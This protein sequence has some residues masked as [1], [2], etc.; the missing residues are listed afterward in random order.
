M[1]DAN[2]FMQAYRDLQHK[3]PKQTEWTEGLKCLADKA[4]AASDEAW[5][6]FFIGRIA[7][8]EERHLEAVGCFQKALD[9][10][11]DHAFSLF[12]RGASLG[13]LERSDEAIAVYDDI[14]TR[15]G[16]SKD[17]A[18]LEVVVMALVNKAAM[19]AERGHPEE[20]IAACD[21]VIVRFGA[22][23]DATLQEGVA[24]A[25]VTRGSMLFRLERHGE[26]IAIYDAVDARFGTSGD[27]FLLDVVALALVNKGV[28]LGKMG[29]YDEAIAT[30]NDAI[31]RFDTSED[32]A[33][34]RHVAVAL[35][36]IGIEL[37][38]MGRHEEAI[39]TYDEV[40]N[41]FSTSDDLALQKQARKALV[42][43]GVEF[44]K[45]GRHEEAV[46]TLDIVINRFGDSEDPAVLE[47]VARAMDSKGVWFGQMDHHDEAI[48]A[49]NDV[50]T[51]FGASK[52]PVLLTQVAEAL[53][54]KGIEFSRMLR[55]DEEIAAYNEVM[56][57][58]GAHEKY[59]TS[60]PVTRALSFKACR[61][62]SQGNVAIAKQCLEEAES[63]APD[64]YFVRRTRA[65]LT[66][67][68]TTASDKEKSEARVAAVD[69]AGDNHV[70]QIQMYLELLNKHF[71][72]K[73]QSYFTMMS[74][75]RERVVEFLKPESAFS[76]DAS[77]LMVLR[78]W[79]SYTPAIPDQDEAD[80]GGGY[81]I[82]HRG[83]GIVIDPGF[84]FLV[85]FHQAGGRM[86][87][88]DHIVVTH[89]HNDH[90]ADV[91]SLLNLLFNY[92]KERKD[93]KKK[94]LRKRVKLY[95]SVGAQ[96]KLAGIIP[97]RGND[98]IDNV[99]TLNRASRQAPQVLELYEGVRLTVL[100]AYHDDVATRDTAVGLG[101]EFRYPD[102][103]EARRVVFTGDTGLYP[104]P[105]DPQGHYRSGNDAVDVR[106]EV[107]LYNQ[108]PE[109]LSQTGV[110]DL[111]VAH[112][113]S[114]KKQEFKE[115]PFYCDPNSDPTFYQNHLGLL[116]TLI[117][118]DQLTPKCAIISEFGE[119]LKDI[120]V[121]L[122][123]EIDKCLALRC[124][125]QGKP[126]FRILPGDLTITY[127]IRD[128][129]FLCHNT[130]EFHA[131]EEL[132]VKSGADLSKG[133]NTRSGI[134][135]PYLLTEYDMSDIDL[136]TEA[137]KEYFKKRDKQGLPYFAPKRDDSG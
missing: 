116:G 45:V 52:D 99:V 97:L 47:Q 10:D 57:R 127:S 85:N 115:S 95:L 117:L 22:S 67:L 14:I 94:E 23:K 53:V 29:R 103:D 70:R 87:D 72:D 109:S 26:A 119:E 86:H 49:F 4:K 12:Y 16:T 79:N 9:I 136:P 43:K 93:E 106:E 114:I 75:R 25:L 39:A 98:Y 100:P 56:T 110:I 17:P 20:A 122:V 36:S 108:Y 107:A 111:L 44:G 34:M 1:A 21:A 105:K 112:I 35:Y 48:A 61:L 129:Q 77:V 91:E 40:F 101:F 30:Y 8:K 32:V 83:Q 80:R 68:N 74:K 60:E 81:F 7:Q 135:R 126:A 54:N 50:I 62:A 64:N 132:I 18:L 6:H 2:F 130:H 41:R 134:T 82:R 66:E 73:K 104:R 51:H 131:P 78:E 84:D 133:E 121:S 88:V 96:R 58:F 118:L 120:K 15:S 113:G 59:R 89:A 69:A 76:S 42:N 90:T 38:K 31:R 102:Q 11:R 19:F 37:G 3:R 124:Q 125:D 28:V 128:R 92:N 63:R 13:K 27:L 46:A 33:L 24:R 123:K 5:Y 55:Y 71:G 65:F 137:L